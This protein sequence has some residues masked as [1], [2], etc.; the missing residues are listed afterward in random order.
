MHSISLY[1]HW[2]SNVPLGTTICVTGII[3][4][5]ISVYIWRRIAGKSHQFCH[6]TAIYLFALGIVDIILLTLFFLTESLSTA[7]P[8]VKTSW[9]YAV[10]H[11]WIL[12]PLL[13]I[14]T[15]ASIW[16]IVGVTVNRWVLITF[17]LQSRALYTT[18][19]TFIGLAAITLFAS[20]VNVP[21]WFKYT[22]VKGVNGTAF[23][24]LTKYGSSDAYMRYELWGHCIVL[25]LVPWLT[26]AVLN[27]LMV[28]T[29]RNRMKLI[30]CPSSKYY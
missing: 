18:K 19:N 26:I 1:F 22:A 2:L 5:I 25:V 12:Y 16:I 10:A 27:V 15:V 30:S 20:F 21:H 24:N 14:F 4:N 28:K 29:L 6:S 8:S 11:A 23:I 13:G 17:P 3:G 9:T 7:A